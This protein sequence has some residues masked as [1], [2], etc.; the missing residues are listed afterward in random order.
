VFGIAPA[1]QALKTDLVPALRSAG[2]TASARR[3]TIGRN[4]LVVSQVALS[5]VLLVATGMLLDGFRKV[6]VMN[7]GFRIDHIMTMDFDTTLVPA[8]SLLPRPRT[9]FTAT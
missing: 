1:W 3:R 2:L 4:A 7:P 6:L 9:S 8:S 5:L